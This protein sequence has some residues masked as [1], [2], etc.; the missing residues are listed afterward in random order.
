MSILIEMGLIAL[1]W[2]TTILKALLISL[3]AN[4]ANILVFQ[5]LNW[6]DIHPINSLFI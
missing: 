2:D 3:L 5:L 4:G 6:L 1:F